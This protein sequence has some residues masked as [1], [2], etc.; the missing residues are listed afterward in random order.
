MK[1]RAF[2]SLCLLAFVLLGASV[3]P[4]RTVLAQNVCSAVAPGNLYAELVPVT[5]PIGA[6]ELRVCSFEPVY[7]D[8]TAASPVTETRANYAYPVGMT[9]AVTSTLHITTTTTSMD[10]DVALLTQIGDAVDYGGIHMEYDG[11]DWATPIYLAMYTYE[12]GRRNMMTTHGTDYFV[13]G[14]TDVWNWNEGSW[15]AWA[16][17]LWFYPEADTFSTTNVVGT[18]CDSIVPFEPYA[19][20]LDDGRIGVCSDTDPMVNGDLMITE[21]NPDTLFNWVSETSVLGLVEITAGGQVVEG[22]AILLEANTVYAGPICLSSG[23]FQIGVFEYTNYPD[24]SPYQ[25]IIALS[26]FAYNLP[27]LGD[28]ILSVFEQTSGGNI[29]VPTPPS[30]WYTQ[31][32]FAN[33][34]IPAT[35]C[36]ASVPFT[37]F[38][39]AKDGNAGVCSGSEPVPFVNGISATPEEDPLTPFNWQGPGVLSSVVITT[40]TTA[41]VGEYTYLGANECLEPPFGLCAGDFPVEVISYDNSAS[42]TDTHIFAVRG[43]GYD[44]SQYEFGYAL[45]YYHNGDWVT[46][47]VWDEYMIMKVEQFRQ[48]LPI[49]VKH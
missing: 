48:S 23:D 47:P 14:V 5:G 34:V 25:D 16:G 15:F 37:P 39:W 20:V 38:A 24:Q 30:V 22:N 4:L 35:D 26:G 1:R 7:V 44:T 2:L 43:F 13:N 6:A 32:S 11:G 42:G 12:N 28:G 31:M 3:V 41:V 17:N 36:D 45:S 21:D 29:W 27:C 9:P 33:K 19:W 49:V 46:E 40:P 8:G 18:E 10:I